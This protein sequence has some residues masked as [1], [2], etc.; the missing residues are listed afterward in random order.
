V[1][2][3]LFAIIYWLQ[4]QQDGD[5]GGL[6]NLGRFGPV[7]QGLAISVIDITILVFTTLWI[8]GKS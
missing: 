4:I 8:A 1:W 2:N 6:F 3:A 7:T 5:P